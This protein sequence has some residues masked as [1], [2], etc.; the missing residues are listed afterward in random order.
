M[1]T[2]R[3]DLQSQEEV[4]RELRLLLDQRPDAVPVGTWGSEA[5]LCDAV[6]EYLAWRIAGINGETALKTGARFLPSPAPIG[7]KGERGHELS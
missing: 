2:L 6:E 4:T 7:V 1:P 5:E 3:K